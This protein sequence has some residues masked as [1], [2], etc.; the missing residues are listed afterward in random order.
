MSTSYL[1]DQWNIIHVVRLGRR[2]KALIDS[3]FSNIFL[4]QNFLLQV[5]LFPVRPPPFPCSVSVRK[6]K[7][8]LADSSHNNLSL[9][10]LRQHL[11]QQQ[12]QLL[13]IYICVYAQWMVLLDHI[14]CTWCKD[15]AYCYWCSTVCVSVGH[16]HELC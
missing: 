6:S 1:W 5:F 2:L 7:H 3:S 13:I 15:A 9:V 4:L 10:D 8:L 12:Q 16:N 11:Q 14:T